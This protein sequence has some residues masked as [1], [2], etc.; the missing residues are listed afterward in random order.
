[1]GQSDKPICVIEDNKAIRKL[2]CT[3][4][5]KSGFETVDFEFADPAIEWLQAN[6]PQAM[7]IDILLPGK[8]S[9]TEVLSALRELP[10]GNKVPAIAVTGFAQGNDREK[11]ISM[12]F[13]SYIA[14]PIN[15]ASF[16][17]EIK[18]VIA[19]KGQ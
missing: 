5:K 2:F 4:L 12:G 19:N 13:D 6:S 1:M 11:F 9:G 8:K 17:D 7:I 14:K 18:Q 16:V 15:T 3:L 10:D